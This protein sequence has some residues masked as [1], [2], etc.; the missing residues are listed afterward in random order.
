MGIQKARYWR[1]LHGYPER[2]DSR[3]GGF[4]SGGTYDGRGGVRNFSPDFWPD[5]GVLST[6]ISRALMEYDSIVRQVKAASV[7]PIDPSLRTRD[8]TKFEELRKEAGISET[9]KYTG[10]F[11][12]E[13]LKSTLAEISVLL[14]FNKSRPLASIVR[15]SSNQELQKILGDE[16]EV[17]DH[18][19]D[20][21]IDDREFPLKDPEADV[22]WQARCLPGVRLIIA[23]PDA[24]SN[25]VEQCQQKSAKK[26]DFN[27]KTVLYIDRQEQRLLEKSLE[28]PHH[29]L[30]EVGTPLRTAY[31]GLSNDFW[32]G[33]DPTSPEYSSSPKQ[34]LRSQQQRFHTVWRRIA[35]ETFPGM[36][37]K[38]VNQEIREQL[39]DIGVDP[40]GFNVDKLHRLYL[41]KKLGIEF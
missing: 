27:E 19:R 7:L 9:G 30:P 40:S 17:R 8:P 37:I 41:S 25:L 22:L 4:E 10:N 18:L 31:L 15:Q 33:L 14:W 20:T 6:V 11:N 3:Y 28:I 36:G 38:E 34:Y 26:L 23:F 16:E 2:G 1:S 29:V 5:T 24:W 32:H 13:T 21:S 12:A 35:H 39:R